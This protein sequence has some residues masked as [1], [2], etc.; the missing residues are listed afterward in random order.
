MEMLE[1]RGTGPRIKR[2]TLVFVAPDKTRL[3][4]LTLAACQYLAWKSIFEER[5][6]L[7][8]DPFQTNQAK[9]KTQQSDDTVQ[10]RI[11]ETYQWLLVAGQPDPQQSTQ[12]QAIRLKAKTVSLCE[13]RKTHQRGVAGH[14]VRRHA[15]ADGSGQGAALA[16]TTSRSS[17]WLRMSLNTSTCHDS[18][19]RP[20]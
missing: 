2:N 16:A 12:W 6:S 3:E 14:S 9:T 19:T 20:C 15:A 8:L 5:E 4:E 13:P 17:N 11:P 1:H 10:A 18:R 7:N